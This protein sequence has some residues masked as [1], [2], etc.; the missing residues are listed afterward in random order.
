MSNPGGRPQNPELDAVI[1]EA[2]IVLLRERGYSGLRVDDI[3]ASTGSAKTTIYRRWPSLRHLVVAAMERA[4]G[5]V[6]EVSDSD[7]VASLERLLRE[8]SDAMHSHALLGTALD[9]LSS[10]DAE[11]RRRYRERVID[12]VRDRA[13]ALISAAVGEDAV[14]NGT[15]PA[16]LADA[17]IGGLIYRAGVLGDPVTGDDLKSF[18]DGILAPR[19]PPA[20]DPR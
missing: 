11:L 1:L 13:V 7:A 10:D 8:R 4:V 9:L 16:V 12:P 2:T 17:L 3:A 15:D 18:I 20:L 6:P 5:G 19:I 14:G